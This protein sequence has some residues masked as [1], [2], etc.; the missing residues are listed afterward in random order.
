MIRHG[1]MHDMTYPTHIHPTASA[2]TLVAARCV[3][4]LRGE[5]TWL[6]SADEMR[7]NEKQ[8][9]DPRPALAGR[10]AG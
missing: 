10:R 2:G 6:L 3:R 5:R 9:F 1:D 4:P 7:G 8:S